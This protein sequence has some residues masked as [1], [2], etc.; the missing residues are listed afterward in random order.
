MPQEPPQCLTPPV[1]PLGIPAGSHNV[2]LEAPELQQT[3]ARPTAATSE[4]AAQAEMLTSG[5]TG[6]PVD[7]SAAFE[8]GDVLLDHLSLANDQLRQLLAAAGCSPAPAAVGPTAVVVGDD[9]LTPGGSPCSESA[10]FRA[11]DNDSH[12]FEG[13]RGVTDSCGGMSDMFG[14]LSLDGSCA[15][16]PRVSFTGSRLPSEA[17]WGGAESLEEAGTSERSLCSGVRYVPASPRVVGFDCPLTPHTA[18]RS[19]S[20]R[21]DCGADGSVTPGGASV[22]Q[23]LAAAAAGGGGGGGLGYSCSGGSGCST[24]RRQP[25]SPGLLHQAL[26]RQQ[27]IS[28]GSGSSTPSGRRAAAAAAAA[29]GAAAAF[30]PAG[31]LA[32]P[33]PGFY[34]SSSSS[35]LLHGAGGPVAVGSA[36]QHH[37]RQRSCGSNT[38][39]M[40]LTGQLQQP[41][42]QQVHPYTQ[43]PVPLPLQHHAALGGGPAMLRAF[44]DSHQALRRHQTKAGSPQHSSSGR[45]SGPFISSWLDGNEDSPLTIS[46]ATT[47]DEVSWKAGCWGVAKTVSC[48]T[49]PSLVSRSASPDGQV[50]YVF[51]SSMAAAINPSATAHQGDAALPAVPAEIDSDTQL[52]YYYYDDFADDTQQASDISSS[53]MRAFMA[54]NIGNQAAANILATEVPKA[55][56]QAVAHAANKT[57]VIKQDGP[58]Q[59]NTTLDGWSLFNIT[60]T[61][62]PITVV[63]QRVEAA[64]ARVGNATQA[65]L[66]GRRN[67]TFNAAAAFNPAKPSWLSTDALEVDADVYKRD[68]SR[69]SRI[70]AALMAAGRT[71][72]SNNKAQQLVVNMGP[73]LQGVLDSTIRQAAT[74]G[75]EVTSAARTNA[76]AAPGKHEFRSYILLMDVQYQQA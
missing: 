50:V 16:G 65:A 49:L 41:P 56:K 53:L 67:N 38:L 1:A 44:S 35:T 48:L 11:G 33:P 12:F 40:M 76:E 22:I 7:S 5:Q 13:L 30:G 59:A 73:G 66:T 55:Y 10:F 24:P 17:G 18:L 34:G 72:V 51:D 26:S 69:T 45:S 2:P 68:A 46:S 20:W 3:A 54:A 31:G 27:L 57:T 60:R 29:V 71:A 9:G 75:A 63:S 36:G 15:G 4:P 28:G 21:S 32:I 47:R 70:I 42:L 25:T 37:Q 8:P 52:F 6:C 23:G 19:P 43:Q 74:R 64:R 61:L 62:D 14:R 58:A 39:M